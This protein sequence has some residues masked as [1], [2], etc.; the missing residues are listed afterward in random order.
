MDVVHLKKG[1]DLRMAG[2]PALELE[3][4]LRPNR[5]AAVAERLRFAKPRLAAKV[6]DRVKV[7]SLLFT[8]KRRP[9]LQFRSPG[10]GTVCAVNFGYRRRLQEVVI[11]LDAEERYEAF[12]RISEDDLDS[13]DRNRLVE[14]IIAGGLWSLIR[15]FP[16]RDAARPETVPPVLYVGLDNLEPFHP[17]PE[18]YLRERHDLMTF[19]LK[20]LARI[21]GAPAVVT[22][23]RTRTAQLAPLMRE[24]RTKFYEEL[25]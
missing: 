12:E 1:Y 17:V 18:V 23:C 14:L 24:A 9:E 5:V 3:D 6:G 15:E 10:G 13:V 19:G 25:A 2:R 16:F 8:D 22:A 4:L 7:G 21:A 11:E 20:V